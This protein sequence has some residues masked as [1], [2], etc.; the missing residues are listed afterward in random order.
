MAHFCEKMAALI[1][2]HF[3]AAAAAAAKKVALSMLIVGC[4]CCYCY[5]NRH[6]NSATN[7]IIRT[8][9]VGKTVTQCRTAC[10]LIVFGLFEQFL[11]ALHS[12]RGTPFVFF[13]CILKSV[14][15]YNAD[16]I[17]YKRFLLLCFWLT[18]CHVLHKTTGEKRRTENSHFVF[19]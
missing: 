17:S 15:E 12:V 7:Q 6:N 11:S 19:N 8:H 1:S 3:V 18:I 2:C 14:I 13:S 9:N 10:V 4:C 16:I 5:T